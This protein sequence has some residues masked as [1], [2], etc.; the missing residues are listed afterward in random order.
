MLEWQAAAA[1][2]LVMQADL[3]QAGGFGLVPLA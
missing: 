1:K 2:M 3:R